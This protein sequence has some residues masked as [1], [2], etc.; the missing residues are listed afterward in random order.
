MEFS[1]LK[2]RLKRLDAACICDASKTFRVMDPGIRPVFQEIKMIGIARTIHCRGD[3]LSVIKALEEANEDEILVIDAEGDKV[4]F[5]GEMF[6]TEAQRKK[7]A[8]MV[9]DGGCRDVKQIRK[10]RFPVYARFQTPLAGGASKPFK[11]QIKVSCGGVSVFP[12]DILFG[13]DD[14]VV[15]MSE[16]EINSILD[17]AESVQTTEE[18]V[19]KKMEAGSSLF[20]LM[21]FSGHYEKVSKGQ[22]SKLTFTV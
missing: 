17:I 10:I 8:G 1:E 5:A 22:E 3:F 12:G 4:A 11:T 9:I 2:K 19:M 16:N 6:A 7:L 14:G 21:N 18:K 20:H 13:D 15:V